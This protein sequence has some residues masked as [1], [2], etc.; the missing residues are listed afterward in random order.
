MFNLTALGKLRVG[1][2]ELTSSECFPCAI[3]LL[4]H[5]DVYYSAHG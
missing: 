4:Q 1:C 3:G 2:L 5:C